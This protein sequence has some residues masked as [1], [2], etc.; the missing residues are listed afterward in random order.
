MDELSNALCSSS[1]AK[2]N[3]IL[4]YQNDVYIRDDAP[5]F[6]LLE[7]RR[8]LGRAFI[9]VILTPEA[10]EEMLAKIWQQSS[11]VS[12]Q[13]VDDMDADIDLMALT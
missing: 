13:L 6:A 12:Q 2:D 10:F 7:M 8:V 4:F 9:P 5:A 1:Y 11:G 3:G